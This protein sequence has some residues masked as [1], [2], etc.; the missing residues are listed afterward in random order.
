MQPVRNAYKFFLQTLRHHDNRPRS[1]A[2]GRSLNNLSMGGCFISCYDFV[3]PMED[4]P[5][6][7]W[8]IERKSLEADLVRLQITLAQSAGH[9]TLEQMD[10]LGV[11]IDKAVQITDRASLEALARLARNGSS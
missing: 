10:R 5:L 1:F 2:F 11:S 7:R 4:N 9:I 8:I 3:M 6:A